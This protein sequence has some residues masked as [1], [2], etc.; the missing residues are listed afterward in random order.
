MFKTYIVTDDMDPKI[1]EYVLGD[2]SQ[3]TFIP[4]PTE[5]D[6]IKNCKDADALIS[7][8][9]PIGAKV[10]DNLPDLKLISLLSIGFDTID[11]DYAR[12]KNIYVS[13]NPNYCI[14]E[15]ADHTVAFILAL[16]RRL[17]EYNRAVKEEKIWQ[18]H[19]IKGNIHRLSK[20]TLGLAGFGK[21]AQ[22]V[23]KRMKAF[24][25]EILAY[26]PYI[27][28]EV[29]ERYG[30]RMVS[31][32]ELLENSH[33]ISLHMPLNDSTK[34]FFNRDVFSKMKKSPI[35][36]NC[37]RGGVVDE[38]AL[39]EAL[40]KGWVSAAGL[41]VLSTE[42]PDLENCEFV[43]RDNV[44]LTP[45]AAFYSVESNEEA[46]ILAAKHV[47]YFIKGQL[48]KIPLIVK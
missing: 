28:K 27:D 42:E 18:Y 45:H 36:I 24:G 15:V 47:E 8:Y 34:N 38:E 48:E 6:I 25:C 19:N 1:A 11:I 46:Q 44:I 7:L 35:F 3:V 16:N 26:D 22:N 21:I 29:G 17:F 10:M 30:V 12:K 41:D 31:L 14:E 5:E 39:L 37:A 13:N 2:Y 20:Q 32:D 40:D 4:S 33:I 23:A 9:E 43:K